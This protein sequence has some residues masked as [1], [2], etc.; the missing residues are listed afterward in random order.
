MCWGWSRST[1]E[2]SGDRDGGGPEGRGRIALLPAGDLFEDFYDKIGV[3]LEDFLLRYR[4]TWL[5]NFVEGLKGQGVDTVLLFVSKRVARTERFIHTP[6]G[7]QVCV[8]PAP[9]AHIK[10]RNLSVRVGS[11]DKAFRSIASY[12]SLPLRTLARELRRSGCD[13]VVCQEYE[14]ARFD[15]CVALGKFLRIPVFAT[16]QGAD[17]PA[18]RLESLPRRISLRTCS[19]VMV[20]ASAEV[21][22]LRRSYGVSGD[23]VAHIPNSVDVRI[24]RSHQREE[25]RR[26][27]A[28]SPA[29]CV[30][31]WHGRVQIERKGLDLL[32]VAWRALR[33]TREKDDLK[34]LL[35]G[36][37]RNRALLRQMI[38]ELPRP[39]EVIWIDRYI[40]DPVMLARHLSAADIYCLPS[41]H[42][43]FSVAVLEAMA[44]GLPV[45]AADVS[46]ISDVF[47]EMGR[48]GG[49]VVPAGSAED[50]AE[51][52]GAL[53]DDPARRRALGAAARHRVE[54]AFSIDAVGR[55]VWD[56]LRS[57]GVSVTRTRG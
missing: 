41:R 25:T 43:G 17:S 23:K 6:S 54:E 36:S 34:L 22:R 53:V 44:C 38:D 24:W 14:T 10:L 28:V 2:A 39:A 3:S 56:F 15:L 1:E 30:I 11:D 27:L 49:I 8:L 42:E 4:S 50:L 31:A 55:R 12:L 19:G 16:Y 52:L 29:T 21:A 9:R 37:G 48:L 18:S 5:F 40:H 13:A 20:G 35:V 45:V 57:R 32:M 46:G 7:A 47:G 33:S 26:E 51:E